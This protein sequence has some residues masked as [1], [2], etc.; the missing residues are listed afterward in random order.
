MSRC[1]QRMRGT[2]SPPSLARSLRLAAAPN[3]ASA[4][5][6][7]ALPQGEHA[8]Y[9]SRNI[10]RKTD[11]CQAEAEAEVS[12]SV[13]LRIRARKESQNNEKRQRASSHVAGAHSGATDYFL[14]E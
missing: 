14:R 6:E 10:G 11:L 8:S 1:Y 12:R 3:D 5:T 2:R 9:P 7:A 13:L 4:I